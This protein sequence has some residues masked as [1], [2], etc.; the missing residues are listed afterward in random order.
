MT[1]MVECP[2]AQMV[3]VSIART[4]QPPKSKEEVCHYER[5]PMTETR[6]PLACCKPVLHMIKLFEANY[7]HV[8][9]RE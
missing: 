9:T 6:E 3:S 8:K 4:K 2:L 1:T 5:V 7:M